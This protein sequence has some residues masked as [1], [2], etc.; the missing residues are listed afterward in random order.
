MGTESWLARAFLSYSRNSV[1]SVRR[2]LMVV[3]RSSVHE[4]LIIASEFLEGIESTD[5]YPIVA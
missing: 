2:L 1:Q 3:V 5:L 4:L